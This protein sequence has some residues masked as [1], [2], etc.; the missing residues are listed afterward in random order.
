MSKSK[1]PPEETGPRCAQC[2]HYKRESNEGD[3]IGTCRRYPPLV[4]I[5][6]EEPWTLFPMVEA[7]VDWCGEFS[8]LN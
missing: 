2:R 8:P 7:G 4:V 6:E 1:K 5:S 3:D